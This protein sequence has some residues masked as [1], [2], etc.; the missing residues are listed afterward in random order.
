[1]TLEV[2]TG[3]PCRVGD[4]K[5][6]TEEGGPASTVMIPRT[7]RQ[8]QTYIARQGGGV[9]SCHAWPWSY[10]HRPSHPYNAGT[11]HV[12]F[13][14]TRQTLPA[15]SAKRR[16]VIGESH[17]GP[18]AFLVILL[19]FAL[20]V[21]PT[22]NIGPIQHDA[23]KTVSSTRSRSFWYMLC[24]ETSFSS[25]P[26]CCDSISEAQSTSISKQKIKP[27]RAI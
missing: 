13:S 18:E 7:D 6:V 4:R 20:L 12:G 21:S 2:P 3:R 27:T 19:R 11:E 14:P 15:P 5:T 26:P 22:K 24:R 10:D 1:M 17:E 8:T 9:C 23:I 16:E 25:R